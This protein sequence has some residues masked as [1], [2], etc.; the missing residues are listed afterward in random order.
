MDELTWTGNAG[1]I[2]VPVIEVAVLALALALLAKLLFV[3]AGLD[4]PRLPGPDGTTTGRS[5]GDLASMAIRASF[6]AALAAF[7]CI[8]AAGAVMP[9]PVE[10]GIIP[11]MAVRF[12][13][14]WLALIA[15]FVLSIRFRRRLGLYGKLFDS[16]V[17]MIGFAIVMFWVFTAIFAD[18]IIT[19]DPF[20][21]LSGLKNKVPGIA[22]TE[23]P[24]GWYLLGGD[25]LARDVFSR[26]VM[27]AREVL[28]IAPAA[29]LFAFM[30]GITLGLPAG[31]FGGRLDTV[32]SFLAN[33]VLA[34]PVIL[35]FY[36]LVTPEIRD[37]G[38]P[39]VLAALLFIFPIIF[40]CTLW[41][42]RYYTNP[43][44]RN[45]Y[46]GITL[47]IG[48]WTYSGLAFNMD[49][50]GVWSMEPNMLNVFVSVVFVNS[51]GVFR[52]V[53]GLV[54]DIKA[55]DYVAAGQTR[56]EGP[57]YIMLWEILPNARGP[58]IVDFCL[59][60]GYT[61]ILLGTLGF[62]GLGV[63]PDSPDWGSTI[64]DGR[65]LLNLFP[66]PAL[67]PALALMSLVLGLNLLA[68]GLREE[69][70]KD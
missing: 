70:L 58:L 51:P 10:A 64:D 29:T 32:I 54:M 9:T 3:L 8:L 43:P 53:R 18:V 11:S 12:W 33:L 2:L 6:Y 21:Q 35:L 69:S 13:P 42:S 38:I 17:G 68:D 49:P 46:V 63:S 28:K 61:T 30:V 45:L 15:T 40:L 16:T 56:G 22:A 14:V 20:L 24:Y 47:L 41:N 23:S 65:K 7:A 62:F 1:N 50:L 44:R 25:H 39:I 4:A 59:R 48:L 67:A 34:F 55:R 60:I 57:W 5:P 31:Y 66:H 19:Q 26:M 27:G 36:L 52:I 37:T